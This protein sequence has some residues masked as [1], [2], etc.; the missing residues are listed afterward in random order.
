MLF[1]MCSCVMGEVVSCFLGANWF[2]IL[3]VV[4]LDRWLAS[5]WMGNVVQC[6][7]GV[8]GNVLCAIDFLIFLLV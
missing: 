1:Q 5:L 7:L 8:N 4:V 6:F 2:G 3:V